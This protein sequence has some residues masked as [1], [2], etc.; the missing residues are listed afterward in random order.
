MFRFQDKQFTTKNKCSYLNIVSSALYPQDCSKNIK[1][2]KWNLCSYLPCSENKVLR[3]LNYLIKNVPFLRGA[4]E[5]YIELSRLNTT[6][7]IL[8]TE[9]VAL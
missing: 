1:S 3:N 8:D 5:N 6:A 9:P 7:L 4:G 2:P